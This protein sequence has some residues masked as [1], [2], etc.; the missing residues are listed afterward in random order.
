M[1]LP[2][3]LSQ[4]YISIDSTVYLNIESNLDIGAEGDFNMHYVIVFSTSNVGMTDL[5]ALL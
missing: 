1:W 2:I 3:L 4:F 5:P